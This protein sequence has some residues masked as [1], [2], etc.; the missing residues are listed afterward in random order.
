[1]SNVATALGIGGDRN[2][3]VRPDGVFGPEL[4]RL[5]GSTI[6]RQLQLQ[7]AVEQSANP[8][9]RVTIDRRSR[10]AMGNL[11]PVI[12]YD[13]DQH[14]RDGLFAARKVARKIFDHL[15]ATDY[16]DH[17]PRDGVPPLGHFVHTVDGETLDL[18]YSGA[19]HGAGTHIMGSSAGTS[20]VDGYQRT[21]EH[22]NL[23]AVGCGSMPSIGT[24][25][26]T[27]TMLALALRSAEQIHKDLLLDRRPADLRGTAGATDAEVPA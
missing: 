23:Y 4:R 6:G 17:A 14:T 9:N 8:N 16:T 22:P 11:R 20:V 12:T 10:D 27:I 24:S 15:G 26:P 25:N 21:W 19:G 5:L 18:A 1:M 13:L 7:I 2:G 3:D